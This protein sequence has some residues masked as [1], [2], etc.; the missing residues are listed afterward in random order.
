MET[1]RK[2]ALAKNETQYFTGKPCVALH[3]ANRRA[4]T[5][6]CIQCRIEKLSLWRQ[7]NPLKVKQHNSQQ[8]KAHSEKIKVSSKEYYLQNKEK[9]V[10][11]TA[12]YRKNNP[13]IIAKCTAKQ[14]AERLKRVPSWLTE[15]DHWMIDQAYELAALRTKMFGFAWHVDHIIPL[16]GKIVSG[17][18][19]PTNL[20]VIPWL[21]NIK[22]HNRYEVNP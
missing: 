9:R 16:Q 10:E 14:K 11:T 5:G 1:T 17:L 22:K 2:A 15:D 13:H 12:T 18:H 20:Q 3:I 4:K 8:Y 6:E 7:K 21:D 19:V